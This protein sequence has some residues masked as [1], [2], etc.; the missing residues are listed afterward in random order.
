M[1]SLIP[2]Y[3]EL[4]LPLAVPQHYTYRIP[5][6]LEDRILPGCRVIVVLGNRRMYTGIVRRLS[7]LPPEGITPRD[8]LEVLD[9]YPMVSELQM[10]FWEWI[11][12]YYM[13]T[14][15]EVYRA[16]LPS[17]LKPE[18]ESK[19]FPEER[20]EEPEG[21]TPTEHRIMDILESEP[22][23]TIH[24]LS[25]SLP[26]MSIMPSVKKLI[27]AG[28]ITLEENIK[29]TYHPRYV[30]YVQLND[31]LSHDKALVDILEV[32]EKRAPKQAGLL[33]KYLDLTREEEDTNSIM[34]SKLLKMADTTHAVLKGLVKKKIFT[35]IS[36]EVSR[37]GL[38]EG[39]TGSQKALN[40][41]QVKVLDSIRSLFASKDVVLLHGVTSSGKTE[42]YI[43]L[44]AEQIKSGKQVLY[45]LPEIALTT[46]IIQRLQ[47]VFGGKV[48]VYHSRFPD[49]QRVEI[50]RNLA[51]VLTGDIEQYQVILGVRS[52]VYLPFSNLGLIIV[53]EEHENT[54]KQFDPA[55]RYNARDAAVVLAG[56]HGAKVLMGT[57]TPSFE[58][59]LNALNDRYG[60]V[61]LTQRFSDIQLPEIEIIN[62]R[63]ARKRKQ[64]KTHFSSILLEEMELALANHEQVILFQNRRG[65]SP[66]VEC[67]A[68]GWI[69]YCRHCD[70]SLTYHKNSNRLVCHYCGYSVVHPASCN[71]CG[72]HDLK[73]R[74]FGTEKVEDE[75]SIL[76]PEAKV[77]RLDLDSARTRRSYE[78]IIED[79]ENRKTDI[80]VGTQMISKGLDF[81]HVRLVGI[82]NAD[83]ML[84]FPDFRSWER[85]YQLMAQVS[86][87][88]GRKNKRGKV[89]IQTGN[90]ENRVLIKIR[91]NDY[92][93]FFMQ[94]M[95]E[96]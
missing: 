21:L 12:D 55:P 40:R 85:S 35:I 5:E 10:K 31:Q 42:I 33:L 34:K 15:G 17:G 38:P 62:L 46:Q 60:L 11:S 63:E 95:A 73:T 91:E 87:R 3:A 29:E 82:L 80:L 70:V 74:G 53:D 19:V 16:A 28:V 72:S 83:N 75:I 76:F 52:S 4:I 58:S 9:E 50:Y 68:C 48:G 37:L 71:S 54:Y 59:Y 45:L 56:V 7:H 13:C 49:N 24:K 22:G 65:F 77:S 57:A 32:L 8:I 79:F 23:I 81:D 93:G 90:P 88:A 36:K 25:G 96:R 27:D 84:N 6:A 2:K 78:R 39:S 43:H 14:T 20:E 51:G 41:H 64:M 1:C 86:G 44:I 47:K 89:I 94:Q 18:S 30:D 92:K 67:N 66:Y 61:E 69:P 26:K